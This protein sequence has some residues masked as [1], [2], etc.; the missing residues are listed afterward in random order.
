MIIRG[1]TI[2]FSSFNKKKNTEKENKLEAD[3]KKLE[4]E[5]SSNI[6]NIDD[7]KLDT[8]GQK[9]NEFIELRNKR[10]EGVML[11]SP[12]RY[13]D[14]REKPSNYFFNLENRNYNNK[15]INKLVN[16]RGN[17]FLKLKIF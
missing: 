4:E 2:Q 8:L 15:V 3:I 11:R 6:N 17:N 16:E 7:G 14:L 12:S 10:I 13:E 5:I 9:K 1:D